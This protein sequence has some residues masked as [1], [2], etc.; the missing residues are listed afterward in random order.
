[1]RKGKV[2]ACLVICLLMLVLGGCGK[3][4]NEIRMG[5]G[6]IGGT[7]YAYGSA[8]GQILSEKQPDITWTVK[9]T[10]GSS[11][12]L[13]LISEGILELGIVQSDVL[14]EAASGIGRFEGKKLG[15]FASVAGLYTEACQ[16]IATADSGI[17][18]LEDLQGKRVSV[19]AEES[20]V[21]INA[22]E[23]LQANGLRIED[24]QASYLSFADSAAAM[25]KGEIDAFFC[26]AGAPTLAVSQLAESMDIRVISLDPRTIRQM[27]NLFGGYV[28]C[29]IPAGTYAGQA[30]DVNTIGVKAVLVAATKA[31]QKTIYGI[32]GE[33][34]ASADKLQY[35]TSVNTPVELSFATEGI[36]MAFHPGAAAY[37]KD[38]GIDVTAGGTSGS[39]GI[40][41]GQD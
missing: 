18:T 1:M 36:P 23:I 15:G 6:G 12:N 17:N 3:T 14:D 35:A 7:Y 2:A 8:L 4:G 19:G 24:L 28:D 10:A 16:V 29:V 27:K 5:T 22:E 39:G 33:L 26:T 21:L 31:D 37:Y 11:A 41:G 32:T 34:F 40:F 9:T 30:E 25:Q 13:R 38:Q 20:G